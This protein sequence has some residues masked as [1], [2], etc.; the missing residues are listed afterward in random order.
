[1]YVY[2]VQNVWKQR[3]KKFEKSKKNNN[4][5]K[6]DWVLHSKII[7]STAKYL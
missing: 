2:E 6:S 3:L 1:M 5:K 4:F 7:Y